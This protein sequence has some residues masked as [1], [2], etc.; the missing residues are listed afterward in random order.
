MNIIFSLFLFILTTTLSC[1]YAGVGLDATRIIYNEGEK[2]VNVGVRNTDS[3]LNYLIQPSVSTDLDKLN[4]AAPFVF[5]PSLF[6][7]ESG[8][9]S[10]VKI[11]VLNHAKLP[12][13]QESLFWFSVTAIP[14]SEKR[15]GISDFDV[16]RGGVKIAVGNTI[17]LIYRPKNLPVSPKEGAKN[18]KFGKTKEGMLKAENGSPYYINLSSLILG[19]RPVKSDNMMMIPP[20]GEL[21]FKGIAPPKDLKEIQWNV[22]NDNGGV[23]NYRF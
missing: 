23:E 8:S 22:I 5:S 13:K 2:A 11:M 15:V 1:A 16:L 7:L 21:V 6:K 12:E 3:K 14:S 19:G 4:N 10:I 17:K 18:L 20:Y 9:E